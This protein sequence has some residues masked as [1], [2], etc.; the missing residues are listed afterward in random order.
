MISFLC[1]MRLAD[2]EHERFK[3]FADVE[4]EFFKG[5]VDSE[6]IICKHVS[7]R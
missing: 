2:L 7:T 6:R 1:I 5:F 3:G 4:H